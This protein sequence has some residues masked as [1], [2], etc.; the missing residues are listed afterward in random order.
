MNPEI[1]LVGGLY[2]FSLDI[3]ARKLADENASYFRLNREHLPSL[4][5]TLEPTVPSLRICGPD[6]E[7]FFGPRLRSILYR[8][9]TFL[10]NSPANPLEPTEQLE[11]S[12][13]S[14][15]LRA[16]TVFDKVFWINHPTKTYQAEC[17]S[18]QLKIAAECGFKVPRSIAT[19][20]VS[21][22]KNI[23]KEYLAVK[24]LDTAYL[25]DKDD[26]IFAYT[27]I[28]QKEELTRNNTKQ[29][30]FF[31]QEA[32]FDKTDIRITIVGNSMWAYKIL[33]DGKKAKGDWRLNKRQQISYESISI[34]LEIQ[35]K[36]VLLC[37]RLG[38]IFAGIDIVE[39]SDGYYFIE[40][41]PT[42]EV[43]WLPGS[44][45]TSASAI[46]THL[47]SGNDLGA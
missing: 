44:D 1:L 40:I 21:Q 8:A 26:I 22:I 31:A 11:R 6:C 37:K 3:I 34:P 43:A 33:V 2:D 30:P 15:F 23:F 32:I 19:N 27:S 16:L 46:V 10:R 36:C 7:F 17:K 4:E 13:W 12:Q 42:G 39:S 25:R 18:Y 47:I 28:V 14:A 5:I 35:M 38:L 24:S 41:N 20:D 29:V 45:Q 9:P